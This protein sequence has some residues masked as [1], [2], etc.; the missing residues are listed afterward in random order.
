[1]RKFTITAICVAI[2][3]LLAITKFNFIALIFGNEQIEVY[4]SNI[5][6]KTSLIYDEPSA[7]HEQDANGQT[8]AAFEQQPAPSPE[9]SLPTIPPTGLFEYKG[10]VDVSD[11][12]PNAIIDQKYAT[13]DNYTGKI[14]YP[15]EVLCLLEK[16]TA[17]ALW[18][19]AQELSTMG[20]RI[21]IWD[22]YRPIEVQWALYNAT[23]DHLKEYAP[24][25]SNTSQH[26]K[27]I[28]I[29]LTLTDKDGNE[30]T[31]PTEF[32]DFS[33]EAHPTYDESDPTK[34]ANRD[35]LISIMKKHGFA[36][37]KNEWWHFYNPTQ[38][39]IDFPD[40]EFSEF[41]QEKARTL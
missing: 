14:L 18:E 12:I 32:D 20:Y 35:L 8:V 39:G 27:G 4:E 34:R 9:S 30:I 26:P 13:T 1:M 6:G 41:T 19:A 33:I 2:I 5:S 10:L 31:M 29:D 23:P 36:V 25:P 38:T 24:A 11:L 7:T 15:E 22:A 16:S 28:A 17:Y 40:V 3:S 37:S 21:K